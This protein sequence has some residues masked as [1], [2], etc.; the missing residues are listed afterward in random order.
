MLPYKIIPRKEWSSTLQKLN[1]ISEETS[2]ATEFV[3]QIEQGNLEATISKQN[4][5]TELIQS[6]VTMRDQMKRF[7]IEEAERRWV[8]EGLAKFV[9]VLRTGNNNLEDLSDRIISGLVQYLKANQGG[10]YLVNDDDA[11]DVFIELLA[12]YAYD[13]KKHLHQ[14]I[15]LGQGILGQAVLEKTPVYMTDVP[16]DFV[17]ITSGLGEALPRT[18]LIMPL[19]LDDKIYGLIEIASFQKL[20]QHE[21]DFVERI[22]ESIAATVSSLKVSDRTSRLLAESQ[23][24]AEEMRAQEEE[25]RQNVEELTATQEEMRRIMK[26]VEGKEAYMASLL[27]VSSDMIFTADREYRLV[28]WNKA[29]E[30][31]VTAFGNRIAKG[32]DTVQWSPPD[33]R[34]AQRNNYERA[35]NGETVEVTTS[36]QIGNDTYHFWNVYAPVRNASGGIGEIA[37]FSKN[38]TELVKAQQKAE[39]LHKEAQ[40]QTEELKAQ[41]EELRQNMEELSA[42]QEEMQRVMN[43]VQA[44]ERFIANIIN[45]SKDSILAIDKDLRVINCNDVF[46]NTYKGIEIGPG[47]DIRNVFGNESEI[48]KYEALYA[49]AFKGEAFEVSEHYTFGD[50]NAHYVISYVPLKNPHGDIDAIAVFVKDVTEI[51][52][53]KSKAEANE[54]TAKNLINVSGDSI[55]TIDHDYKIVL[56]NETFRASFAGM[57]IDVQEGFSVL[58]LF[59][60][61]EAKAKAKAYERAFSGET[62]ESVDHLVVNGHDK[63]YSVK[64]APLFNA[65]GGVDMIA[66]F[67]SDVTE[68]T[69]S[70]MQTEALLRQSQQQ[71]EELRAQEEELRQN[72]DQI[73]EQQQGMRKQLEEIALLRHELE[74]REYAFGYSTILSE[75][76]L[77]GTITFINDKFCNVSG[78]TREELIGKGHNI[79][80]HPDMPKELFKEMW[81]TI[82]KGEVFKGIIKNKT[83]SGGHYWVEATI[84]PVKNTDG[85]VTK[86]IGARYHITNDEAAEKLFQLQMSNAKFK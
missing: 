20:K 42:T 61:D 73:H 5:S 71:T 64:T 9:E 82:K 85:V 30:M 77:H 65:E 43:E 78:F 4:A 47:F 81:R 34:T 16:R 66:I 36:A 32:D 74:T 63:Y 12:C 56:F 72:M 55:M 69:T 52:I 13:R 50:I 27:N 84:V 40:Q 59:S 70:K 28:T 11:S 35:F 15:E 26:E 60:G 58:S 62:I 45:A 46:K 53:A 80:R 41:E 75:A 38:V 37:V 31:S 2:I 14:R 49:R 29:F 57:G 83:K 24:Q 54:R 17:K 86:Y 33:V 21:I 67:A 44:R 19:K 22:G 39:A 79:V 51:T 3:K 8:N 7:A 68:L 25:M 1:D 18:V 6:L 76:D 48:K 23:Q 10:L